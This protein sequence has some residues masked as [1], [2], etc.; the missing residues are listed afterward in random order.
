MFF[1]KYA[2]SYSLYTYKVKKALAFYVNNIVLE[3]IAN[4]KK[5]IDLCSIFQKGNRP[6][7]LKMFLPLKLYILILPALVV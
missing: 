7:D 5:G 4:F 1:S 3:N 2:F 6:K